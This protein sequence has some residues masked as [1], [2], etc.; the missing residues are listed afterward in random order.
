MA[1]FHEQAI[2][3]ANC[4]R[5]ALSPP[6]PSTGGNLNRHDNKAVYD[7]NLVFQSLQMC[8]RSNDTAFWAKVS[9]EHQFNVALTDVD[10]LRTGFVCHIFSGECVSR[11]GDGC[12]AVV[13]NEKWPHS[14]A[15]HVIDDTI[16]R[17]QQ[18]LLSTDDF[19]RTCEG[20]DITARVVNKKRSLVTKLVERRQQLLNMMDAA[21][22]SLTEQLP[23]LAA[24]SSMKVIKS[25]GA[26][27]GVEISKDDT[28]TD[29][30]A[31]I[32]EHITHGNCVEQ[33]RRTPGCER[34][35]EDSISR[36][37]N[38]IHLQISV[39]RCILVNGS[40]KQLTQVLD[41]HDIDHDTT[42]KKKKLRSCLKKYIEN[43]ERG[44]L[45]EVN[46]E[47]EAIERLRKLDEV[48]RNWPKLVPMAVKEKIVKDFQTATSSTALSNFTCACC[49]RDLPIGERIRKAAADI[50]LSLLEGPVAHWND[51]AFLPPP[52][53]FTT[54][55]LKD[56]LIDVHGV[57]MGDDGNVTL[58]LCN[59]CSR[60]LRRGKVPKYALA[61][62]MYVGPVPQELSDLTMIEESMIARARAKS[63]IV[64][65]QEH[66]SVSSSP[67]AQR[68]VKG[69]T[70]IYPQQPGELAS[71]LPR[72][73]A[74]TLTFIC[75]IFVG[76]TTLTKAWLR[77]KAKP[78]V[79]RREK[80]RSALEWLR[81][82]NPLY[83]D[84]KIDGQNL[85]ALP[86]NDVLP[87]HIEHVA[88]S[89]AQ[90]TLVS[91]YNNMNEQPNPAAADTHF[92]S[93]VVADVDAHTPA[94]RLRAAAVHHAKTKGRPFVQIG[95]DAKPVNEFFNVNLFPMIYP[96]LFPYGCGGFEDRTRSVPMSLKEHVK[97]LFSW[98][99]KRFQTH[100]S[101]LFTAFNILQRRALLLG[102]SLKVKKASFSQFAKRF[103]SVSSEA[104][105]HVLERIEKGEGVTAR[106]DDEQKVLRLMKEVNLVTAKVPGS[107]SARVAMR[108]E[109]RALTM[110]HGMPSFYITIN[111]ADTHNP[112]VK[113][114]A[115]AD[116]DV[117]KML[118]DQVPN[119]WEQSI[120][121][122]SNP[123]V[124]ATFFNKYLKAFVRTVLGCNEANVNEDGGI[125]GVVKA[126]Y[127]CV[128]AQGRGS[129]H[130]HM[131]IWI[132]GALNP[133]E[134]RDKVMRD[135]SWG[136]R[137]LD[138]LDDT[139]TNVVPEDPIPDVS[140]LWDDKDPCTLRGVDLEIAN[141]QERLALRMKDV[142]RLAGRVQRH[143]HSHTCYK[144]YKPGSARNCRFDL[145]EENFRS[146][147]AI[148][149][150]TGQIAL[151]CLDGLVNNFNMTIL[152]A[153]R[154]NMDIQFIGSG[155]SAKAMIYY[156]TD[157]ITKS[158]LKA[159][160]SYAA[161]Q[162]AVK[163]CE[164]IDDTDDDFTVRSKRLLQKSA[165]ALILHQELSA[166]Q[167]ASYLMGYKDHFT[168]HRF[169][170]LYWASFER[171]IERQ[172]TDKFC[173]GAAV[174]N[175]DIEIEESGTDLECS[176]ESEQSNRRREVAEA[177]EDAPADDDEEEVSIRA[178]EHGNV[179][180]LVV[181][182]L[183]PGNDRYA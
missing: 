26:T 73:V 122:S 75:V 92:E 115:G 20:L 12:K 123:A 21:T 56:K 54:G 57:V 110:T 52:T 85:D 153:V 78:L 84:I 79:V 125:L 163:K 174:S 25:V 16:R 77:E 151:R 171:F 48:R 124:G 46:A 33:C 47:A 164:S 109:I 80:V 129:L 145:K 183:T 134:I 176:A 4:Q 160:V 128:E 116:I 143:R 71:I 156:V 42:E 13:D 173:D 60:G 55:L 3:D 155:E 177:D 104:V 103:S 141:V 100:Y 180:V 112:I 120:L 68:G 62:K 159:H 132:E 97:T 41:M 6:V 106:T 86:E 168:S 7:M 136:K 70:I 10:A 108:N 66:D 182:N 63:W 37:E 166:Q 49:A 69:H 119:Y 40:K 146:T 65:L 59:A 30:C 61:N 14:M 74:E 36:H 50:D 149:P 101:F 105:G 24:S 29:G 87:Y 107:S 130:C 121:L 5:I 162:V 2:L 90:E 96:T 98:H 91:Q 53:P 43:I 27:H 88:D 64:K 135:T 167:V 11:R 142:N 150:E 51:S 114:L 111:P 126:H 15:I 72:P 179:A 32:L 165:Y 147:S 178:D 137:L 117:D 35:V 118:Q 99:D 172:D 83:K 138:Y 157:Y 144:Y 93:V 1:G 34:L 175:I 9:H 94:S 81:E 44:K 131:L 76:S 31:K 23:K 113:F 158:Q 181:I 67:T 139:I 82:N 152:E 170:C 148:E 28:K 95:R 22:L 38:A 8:L 17:V 102:S 39:L 161:L 89:E 58:E 154:C 127:G 19:V 140:T 18:G 133:N 169:N 45:K